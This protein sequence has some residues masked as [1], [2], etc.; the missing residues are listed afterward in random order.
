MENTLKNACLIKIPGASPLA[1]R[2]TFSFHSKA[3]YSTR[4]LIYFSPQGAGNRTPRDL[5]CFDI[6]D[7][8]IR[9]RVAKCLSGYG[10]RVQRSVFEISVETA[11]ELDDIKNQL[12][13]LIETGDDVRFYSMCLNCRRKSHTTEGE[14]IA[15]YPSVVII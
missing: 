1:K 2:S 12:A 7:D 8:R 3:G 14:R 13:K 5:T 10:V 9:Y 6:S 4:A 11:T 15:I